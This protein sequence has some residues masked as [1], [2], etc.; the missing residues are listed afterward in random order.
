MVQ[1]GA[2]AVEVAY[3]GYFT[4]LVWS[5]TLV[6]MIRVKFQMFS[7]FL[8]SWKISHPSL[9]HQ[10]ALAAMGVNVAQECMAGAKCGA[11]INKARHDIRPASSGG[12]E[13]QI[14]S[15]ELFIGYCSLEAFGEREEV[16]LG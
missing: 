5:F 2:D 7:W 15:L 6:K 16:K 4:T 1:A 10:L 9:V 13:A 11:V 14:S 12:V 3:G 8:L